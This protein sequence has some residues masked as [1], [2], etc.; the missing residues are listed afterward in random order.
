MKKTKI[1][2]LLIAAVAL[3]L[4][5]NMTVKALPSFSVPEKYSVTVGVDDNGH[6]KDTAYIGN[7]EIGYCTG[8]SP[9]M[10]YKLDGGDTVEYGN[11]S[12]TVNEN[13]TGFAKLPISTSSITNSTEHTIEMWIS[14]GTNT[15]EKYT[16][17]FTFRAQ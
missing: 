8:T 2:L 9:T 10:Y 17:E 13:T 12:C 4:T 3:F 14:D 7:Y 11:V 16:Q 5:G 6:L 15:S 1:I